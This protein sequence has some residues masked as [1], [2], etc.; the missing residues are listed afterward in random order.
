[1]NIYGKAVAVAAGS[2]LAGAAFAQSYSTIEQRDRMQQQRI[3]RGVQS[4]QLTSQE[5]ARLQAERNRIESLESRA[6]A[7]G[8]LSRQERA[9]IDQAQDRLGRHIYRE[10][11]DR[12]VADANGHRGNRSQGWDPRRGNGQHGSRPEHPRQHDGSRGAHD[13]RRGR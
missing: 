7:N 9:R 5:A 11:H 12:Q 4:G 1:M 8:N 2:L 3:D 6:R 13:D 10:A